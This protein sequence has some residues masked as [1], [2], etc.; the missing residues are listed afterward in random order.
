MLPDGCSFR[1][2][3][4]C[5]RLLPATETEVLSRY[6]HQPSGCSSEMLDLGAGATFH[7]NPSGGEVAVIAG[8]ILPY[9]FGIFNMLCTN[10][11]RMLLDIFRRFGKLDWYIPGDQEI[12]LRSG[13][14]DGEEI[15]M[16]LNLSLDDCEC[17]KICCTGDRQI[18]GICELTPDGEWAAL[19][20]SRNG[21]KVTIDRELRPLRPLLLKLQ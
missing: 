18:S 5:A 19:P 7:V 13:V 3:G 17:I 12:M 10:R 14:A 20:W 21:E 9:G 1:S 8:F 15:L 6:Y 16:L 11:K 4:T 2:P